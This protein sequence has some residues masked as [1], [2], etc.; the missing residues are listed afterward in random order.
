MKNAVEEN[1]A[2]AKKIKNKAGIKPKITRN[3]S[4]CV[5]LFWT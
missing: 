1:H 4:C 2:D 3:C 5:I